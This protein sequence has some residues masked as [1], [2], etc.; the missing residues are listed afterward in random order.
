MM[1][2]ELLWTLWWETHPCATSSA[3]SLQKQSAR[4][5][6][7]VERLPVHAEVFLEQPQLKKTHAGCAA[8]L[9]PQVVPFENNGGGK[10]ALLPT[11]IAW[12]LSG[13]QVSLLVKFW[14]VFLFLNQLQTKTRF[15]FRGHGR[16][17]FLR[18]QEGG[19]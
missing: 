13:F 9:R 3:S 17:G 5:G 4:I 7:P 18:T 6:I 16:S 10:G 15:L 2:K 12:R 8:H 1:G 19:V 11:E 14:K